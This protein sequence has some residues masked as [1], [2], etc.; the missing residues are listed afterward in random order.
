MQTTCL[1]CYMVEPPSCARNQAG[2]SRHQPRISWG[3]TNI[4]QCHKQQAL[5]QLTNGSVIHYTGL[6]TIRSTD[7]SHPQNETIKTFPIKPLCTVNPPHEIVDWPEKHSVMWRGL[8]WDYSYMANSS[9][10]YVKEGCLFNTTDLLIFPGSKYEHLCTKDRCPGAWVS[11][12]TPHNTIVN[13]LSMSWASDWPI[14]ALPPLSLTSAQSTTIRASIWSS[15]PKT[16]DCCSPFYLHGLTLIPAWISNHM[17]CKVWDEITYP[18]P[19]LQRLHRW[20][21]G[22]DK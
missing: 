22:M 17:P 15:A 2:L 19:K 9:M 7:C 12:H 16:E 5:G 20:S 11:N 1:L 18:I 10:T 13:Y 21:L 8:S 4:S 14:Q 3:K 6:S